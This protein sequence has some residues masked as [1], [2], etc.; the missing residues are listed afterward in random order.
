MNKRGTNAVL[1]IVALLGLALV[2]WFLLSGDV[3]F[4]TSEKDFSTN[5]FESVNYRLRFLDYVF[6][7]IPTYLDN[8]I[9]G[10]SSVII[11]IGVWLLLLLAFGDIISM[12]G[13]FSKGVSWVIAVVLAILA[14]NL[15]FITFMSVYVLS[16]ATVFGAY[17]V[18]VGII[19][20][21]ALFIAF[22]F[23]SEQ[24]QEWVVRKRRR[25]LQLKA[26]KKAAEAGAGLNILRSLGR[27]SRGW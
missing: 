19:L 23:G 2:V 10:T 12:F 14:A 25:E 21:F 15:K 9:G 18:V 11:T 6:G 16:I 4:S 26:A 20:I 1:I 13:S 17:S 24:V 22:H 27:P 5:S 8:S 7:E 3:N